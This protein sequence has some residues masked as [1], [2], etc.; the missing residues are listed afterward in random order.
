MF[1][2]ACSTFSDPSLWHDTKDVKTSVAK[3]GATKQTSAAP[4]QAA[5]AT[6]KDTVVI[7]DATQ[8]TEPVSNHVTSLLLKQGMEALQANRLLSPEGDNAS[9]YFNLVLRRDPNNYQAKKGLATIVD[10]YLQMSLAAAKRQDG[11]AA[12]QYVAMAKQV[13]PRNPSIADVERRVRA[14]PEKKVNSSIS[15]PKSTKSTS[16]NTSS[17]AS[18]Q[19]SKI[20]SQIAADGVYRLPANLFKLSENDILAYLK[21]II[22]QVDSTQAPIEIIW[23]NDKEARLLYQIINSRTPDFRVRAMTSRGSSNMVKV[24]LN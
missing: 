2:S 15:S 16:S 12:R 10:R 3:S 5:V 24:D 17:S 1:L 22:E 23:P 21:P 11:R 9:L 13:D 18:N 19:P 4:K 14:M 6:K 7:I 8:P 20:V